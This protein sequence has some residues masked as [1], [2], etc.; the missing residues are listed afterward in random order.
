MM[1]GWLLALCSY[2]ARSVD[3]G[4]C[5][6]SEVSSLIQGQVASLIFAQTRIGPSKTPFRNTG[7]HGCMHEVAGCVK[8]DDYV[9][10]SMRII[11]PSALLAPIAKPAKEGAF[12]CPTT[13]MNDGILFVL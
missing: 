9:C 11:Q 8:E 7:C 4:G 1:A 12:A 10:I 13:T 6:G 3:M 5:I 2:G